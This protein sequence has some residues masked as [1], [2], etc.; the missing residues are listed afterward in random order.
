MSEPKRQHVVPVSYLRNWS[1]NKNQSRKKSKICVFDANDCRSFISSVNKYPT[2]KNFY[3]I[4]ELGE[5]KQLLEKFFCIIEDQY[6][7]LLL[8]VIQR[9]EDRQNIRNKAEPIIS[10]EDRNELAAQFAMQRVRT[11]DY[12]SFYQYCYTTLK[13]GFP[14][15][16]IPNYTSSD[17]Q[18]LHTTEIMSFK[19]ANFYANLL[20]DRNWVIL[21][22]HSDIPFFTSDNP[23]IFINHSEN[24]SEPISPA[25]KEVTFYIPL[26]PKIAVELYHKSI[27][28][29]P[30][31]CIP[32]DF[33]GIVRGYNKNL[34]KH[35][36]RFMFSNKNDFSCLIRSEK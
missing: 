3:D 21:I 28:K 19:M 13:E 25:A 16:D 27:L 22:N 36:T 29:L 26:S 7:V 9:I 12:R 10:T 17:F 2:E 4:P 11:Q 5:M 6:A 32:I 23:G 24:S 1:I 34:L 30:E 35:C 18:R 15:A 31:I 8:K 14:W 20:S 33:S